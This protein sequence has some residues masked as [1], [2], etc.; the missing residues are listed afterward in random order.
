[1]ERI[2]VRMS[3]V[4]GARCYSSLP[5]VHVIG[6]PFLH[7]APKKLSGVLERVSGFFNCSLGVPLIQVPKKSQALRPY[8]ILVG[9]VVCWG[10][11][12]DQKQHK[13]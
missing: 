2:R 5:I 9:F 3:L 8:K 4:R 6:P 7:S 13:K 1:M 10:R 11:K 12:V